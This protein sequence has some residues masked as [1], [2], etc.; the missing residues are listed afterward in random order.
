MQRTRALHPVCLLWAL[1]LCSALGLDPAAAVAQAPPGPAQLAAA[2]LP[3][4][5]ELR[6]G[7]GVVTVDRQG[8][9][10]IWRASANGMVCLADTPGDSLF[11]V[12]CY[13]ASFIPLIYRV[14]QLIAQGVADSAF[15]ATIDAEIRSGKLVIARE[16]TAGYRMLGPIAGFD[17]AHASVSDTIDAWQ[18]VHMPYRTASSVGLPT[19]EDGTHPYVMAAGTYWAHFL[20]MQ[21]PLRY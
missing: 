5:A 18:S 7:A 14:R 10:H 3:L 11:D 21:R 6:S 8:Q 20:I 19:T 17:S 2:V 16:P 12:R 1:C 9:P 13:Q 15:D 4:P